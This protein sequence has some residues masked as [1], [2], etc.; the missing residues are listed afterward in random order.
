MKSVVAAVSAALMLAA[1][2]PAAAALAVGSPAVPFSA[3]G[4]RDGARVTVDL[5]ELLKR[6][7]VVVFFLPSAF[8]DA[9]ECRD[10][11]ENLAKFQ[12]AGASVVGISRDSTETLARFSAQECPGGFPLAS[13]NERLV[14]DYDVNDSAMFNTR[15]T[16]VVAPT[17]EI[18]FVHDG[19]DYAGHARSALAFVQGMKK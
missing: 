18:V 12:A 15:T 5:A 3:P 1:A 19:D 16:Y 8:T 17:G 10:F 7:P 4:I 2:P 13:A 11:A 9:P 6:G 14:N